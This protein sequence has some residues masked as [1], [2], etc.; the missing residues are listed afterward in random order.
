[1]KVAKRQVLKSIVVNKAIESESQFESSIFNFERMKKIF[2]HQLV[3][4][5]SPINPEKKALQFS[6]SF[7]NDTNNVHEESLKGFCSNDN[8][9]LIL[10]NFLKMCQPSEIID[11]DFYLEN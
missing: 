8:G 2:N 5:S 10:E 11:F 7:S 6:N 1:M 4:S 3:F 9:S